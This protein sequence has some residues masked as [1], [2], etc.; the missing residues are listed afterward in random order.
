MI[1]I[2]SSTIIEAV[3]KKCGLDSSLAFA[4]FYFD[5]KDPS[6]QNHRNLICSLI[7]QLCGRFASIPSTLQGLYSQNL[8]GRQ[9]PTLEALL[10]VLKELCRPFKHTYIVLDALDECTGPERSNVLSFIETLIGWEFDNVH[11][12][13]TSQKD[14]EIEH[15]L[16]SLNC[17]HLDLDMTLIGQDIQIHVHAMLAGDESFKRWKDKEKQL[18]EETLMKGA[19]GM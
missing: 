10:V 17:S 19:N 6:K 12:L 4:Y 11:L 14:P 13:A 18:I 7:I 8:N 1:N 3:K 16:Q 5:F 9:Q 15:C 2:F